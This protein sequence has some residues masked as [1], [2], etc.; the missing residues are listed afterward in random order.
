MA[1][2]NQIDSENN[3]IVRTILGEL[4]MSDILDAIND[5]LADEEFSKDMHVIWNFNDAD[6]SNQTTDDILEIIGHIKNSMDKRGSHYKIALV[7]PEDLSFGISRIFAGYGSELPL[8]IG[9]HRTI[10]D[11]YKWIKSDTE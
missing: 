3:L 1:I 7:A 9:V 2:N 4:T 8:S 5:S 11:A 10:D 6:V